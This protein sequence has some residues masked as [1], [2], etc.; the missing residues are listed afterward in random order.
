VPK[1]ILLLFIAIVDPGIS[2][3]KNFD[4]FPDQ[5]TCLVQGKIWHVKYCPVLKSSVRARLQAGCPAF[6]EGS[7]CCA[8]VGSMFEATTLAFYLIVVSRI[9]GT[10]GWS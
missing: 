2:S 4:V 8:G 7:N 5:L 6:R 9:L 1:K 10:A 3:V